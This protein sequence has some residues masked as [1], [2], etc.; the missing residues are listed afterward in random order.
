MKRALY[1]EEQKDG[2]CL[3]KDA[4]GNTHGYPFPDSIAAGNYRRQN[5]YKFAYDLDAAKKSDADDRVEDDPHTGDTLCQFVGGVLNG[6]S[7][8]VDGLIRE[9]R[10]LGI[11]TGR[12][13]DNSAKR[14]AGCLC[15][16]RIFDNAPTIEGYCGPMWGGIEHPLRYETWDVYNRMSI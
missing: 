4:E 5:G 8:D 11:K 10:R 1:I 16:A 6:K 12:H 15:P 13:A 14:E 7:L 3:L 9:C 2:T